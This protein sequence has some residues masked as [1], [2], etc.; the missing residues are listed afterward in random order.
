MLRQTLFLLK[1]APDQNVEKLIGPTELDIGLHHDRVPALHDRILNFVGA[2]RLL[3]LDPLAKIVALEHLLERHPAVEANDV[4]ETHLSKPIAIENS[5]GSR[6]IENLKCLLAIGCGV[7]H[8]F[9]ARQLRARGRTPTRVPD[10]PGEIADDKNSLM[11]EILKL[12]Q[13]SEDDRV[14]EVNV[15]TGWIDA[16]L[17]AQWP[18]KRDLFTQFGLAD[19]LR[20]PLFQRGERFVRLHEE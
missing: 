11:T 17:D 6:R 13:L 5:F 19:N 10:H 8:H 3:L 16:E 12:P 1:I 9:F 2:N 15:G 14:A 4:F 20:R 18:A 7:R